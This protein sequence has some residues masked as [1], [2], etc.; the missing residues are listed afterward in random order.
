MRIFERHQFYTCLL[1]K[2]LRPSCTELGNLK[3]KCYN[4][5]VHNVA[6]Q[7]SC[8]LNFCSSKISK[9]IFHTLQFANTEGYKGKPVHFLQNL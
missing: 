1:R 4:C 5:A 7:N 3:I 8:K 6:N 9:K 2:M